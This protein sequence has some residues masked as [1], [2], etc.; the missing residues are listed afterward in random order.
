M[1]SAKQ[2]SIP[3]EQLMKDAGRTDTANA[4]RFID[5]YQSQLLYVPPWGKWLSHDGSRWVDDCGVGTMQR[6]KRYSE[7]LWSVVPRQSLLLDREELNKLVSFIRSTNRA[8]GIANFLSLAESDERV[9]CPVDEL[10][11]DPN[12]LN[13]VNGTVD[14]TTGELRAHNPA[15]RITQK[16]NV[17]YDPKAECPEWI[18]TTDL[19]FGG[20]QGLIRYFQQLV[21][22][23][24][25]GDTGEHLLP[26]PHGDGFNGKSTAWNTIT[27]LLGDYASL[28][29]DE[30][31]LGNRN[32]HP[33]EKAAL[34]QKRFVAISEPEKGAKLKESRV[35]ELTG[36]RFITAR[37]MNE[38]FWTFKRTHTFWIST[39]HLPRIDGTDEGIWR[40]VKLIPFT[41]NLRD[42]VKPIPDFDAWLVKHEG[43][44]ILAWMVRGYLDYRQNGLIEPE[45]VTLATAR[46]RA[47]SDELADFIAEYCIVEPHA[48]VSGGDLHRVY[49][50]A[51]GKSG[52][53]KN[54]LGQAMAT[55][56]EKAKIRGKNFY[57]G[58]RLRDES[59]ESTQDEN[60]LKHEENAK[61]GHLGIQLQPTP[62]SPTH[63]PIGSQ[64]YPQ[65][66]PLETLADDEVAF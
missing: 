24:I 30:L 42:K 61:G 18:A 28:A 10:N 7:S 51:T 25:S 64:R 3:G 5:R 12:L 55:R 45:A 11:V 52:M 32:N 39:N 16:T 19:I 66:S 44:G 53:N 37:R 41:V 31:L 58:I 2:Q 33:T 48:K 38:D 23:S 65:V 50:E 8:A 1:N 15:D 60:T 6:A 43:P 21:G 47:D 4:K 57:K 35:K 40:R 63:I 13:C 34:Y 27:E 49:I 54:A 14:L 17:A 56:F 20:D 36:D 29:S 62:D 46:Y 26:I 59:D 9:V 22:Y